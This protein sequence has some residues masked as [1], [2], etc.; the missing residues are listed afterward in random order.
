MPPRAEGPPA[1]GG[2]ARRVAALWRWH[3]RA[4]LFACLL[5]IMLAST[6]LLLNHSDGLGLGKRAVGW[7]WP[8]A[9]YGAKSAGDWLAFEAGGQWVLQ[10]GEE[11][12]Y[13]GARPIGRCEGTLVGALALPQMLL[14]ACERELLLLTLQGERVDA[15]ATASGLPVPIGGLATGEGAPLVLAQERWHRFDPESMQLG[16]AP[17]GAPRVLPAG[18]PPAALLATLGR[19]SGWLDWERLLLDLHSGRLFGSAGV[20][21]VDVGGVLS[22]L[23]A[24]SGVLMWGLRRR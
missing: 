13:L 22:L 8:Y 14:V 10:G 21:V 11:R 20:L 16:V 15:L 17:A 9:L 18:A 4:G 2:R 6:G 24:L 1:G 5:L 3:R 19:S 12:I 7:D 23:L